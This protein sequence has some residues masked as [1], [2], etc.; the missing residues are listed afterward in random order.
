MHFLL[1]VDKNLILQL[2]YNDFFRLFL[3]RL[4]EID[5]IFV[6]EVGELNVVVHWQRHVL[7]ERVEAVVDFAHFENVG[8]VG[9]GV[10]VIVH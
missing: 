1:F 2:L 5:I 8:D 4:R 9:R 6:L 3:S 10:R 7:F